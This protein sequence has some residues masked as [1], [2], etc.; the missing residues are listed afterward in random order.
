MFETIRTQYYP[1]T[2]VDGIVA[3]PIP[4]RSEFFG[5]TGQY[6]DEV[7]TPFDELGAYSIPQER[8]ANLTPLR[9]VF[10]GTHHEYFVFYDGDTVAGWSYG[11]MH[12]PET[13]FM[14]NTA[15]RKAYQ[16]RG[17]YSK[18][19][20]HFI[21]YLTAL[22]YERIT[23]THQPNNR[24]VLMAKLKAGFVLSG[25]ILDERWSAQVQMTYHI[26]PD[27]QQGF[28]RAFSLEFPTGK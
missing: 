11:D 21:D 8:Q 17:I 3:R 13:Y 5:I 2:I 18:F 20:G 14:S 27:R 15:I 7:F 22:G 1:Q 10:A 16:R 28:S 26:H 23:S 25:M 6:F 24:A 19:L 12:D 4:S 9:Q